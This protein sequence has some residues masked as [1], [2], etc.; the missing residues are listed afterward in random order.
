MKTYLF[1]D[2]ET[3]GL[4]PAFDQI[5]TFASIRT[6][7]ELNEIE[8]N[9][10]TLQLRPDIVPSPQ[11][12]IIHRLSYKDL[13]VGLPE[14]EA[15]KKIHKI[16][17]QSG[18]I[19]LGYNTLRFDDEFL[20]FSFYRNLLDPY[21]HQ[22]GNGC[23]RMDIL[24]LATLFYIFKPDLIN[25]PMNN[26]KPSLKL[27]KISEQNSLVTSGRAHEAMTDV[28]ATCNL[29]RIFAKENE[30]FDYSLNFFN[31]Q[32]DEIRINKIE[33]FIKLRGFPFK[34]GIMVSHQLGPD[35]NYMAPVI[36]IGKSIRYSNQSLWLRLDKD[37]I[38]SFISKPEE[39]ISLVVRKRFGDLPIILPAIDR[40]YKKLSDENI[41]KT[42][43]NL[44][45]ISNK[46]DDFFE[47]VNFH[48]EFKYPYV[49]DLDPDASL[50]Q[51]GFFNKHEK[52]EM[53]NFHG[54][55]L[56]GKIQIA[57]QMS[58]DRV[59][60][61]AQRIIQRNYSSESLRTS[62][63]ASSESF[64]FLE[65]MDKIRLSDPENAVKGFRNDTKLNC[66]DAL[67]ELED[68]L[69]IA[70]DNEQNDL[71]EWLKGYIGKM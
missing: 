32:K 11:A 60:I 13:K 48:K 38:L 40:F 31:K 17:N 63:S 41:K 15:V 43:L 61:I 50:Y 29:A 58:S 10:V 14:Y 45:A 46:N 44:K 25:W 30:T 49:P 5:L 55:D 3:S 35:I 70:L 57:K 1:Y 23:S 52:K 66:K 53:S 71:L 59:K 18:T 56:N 42:E 47:I 16:V 68:A 8:R 39:S 4:N 2:I 6:D 22:Y 26:G 54:A 67:Q 37:D 21:T 20:R 28:E 51:D 9:E 34:L 7:K 33:N 24:P 62:E 65:L 19:S 69:K 12:L 64:E 36:N 27:E